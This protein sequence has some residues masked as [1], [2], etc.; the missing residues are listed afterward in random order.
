MRFV[1]KHGDDVATK[2]DAIRDIY[3]KTKLNECWLL[4]NQ[5]IYGDILLA[6]QR[7]EYLR[8]DLSISVV[9]TDSCFN[10][11]LDN[12]LVTTESRFNLVTSTSA[13]N[14]MQKLELASFQ[15]IYSLI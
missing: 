13:N 5:S 10:I 2:P 3:E 9:S 1:V 8:D 11:D 6:L 14:T 7:E 12:Y 4:A 15:G